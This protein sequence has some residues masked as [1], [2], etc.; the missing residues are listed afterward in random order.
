M[1]A[2]SYKLGYIAGLSDLQ[3]ELSARKTANTQQY[4]RNSRGGYDSLAEVFDQ[5]LREIVVIEK[6]IEALKSKKSTLE[7]F[8]DR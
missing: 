1:D 2:E 4:L 3:N 5:R 8:E 6:I 7:L